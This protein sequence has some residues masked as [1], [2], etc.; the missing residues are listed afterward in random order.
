MHQGSSQSLFMMHVAVQ[1]IDL[2]KFRAL[3][4]GVSGCHQDTLKPQSHTF[5]NPII[6]MGNCL[7]CQLQANDLKFSLQSTVYKVLH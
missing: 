4:S 6:L 5:R 3:A 1:G 2:A 7:K